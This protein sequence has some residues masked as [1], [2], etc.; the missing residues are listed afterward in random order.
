MEPGKGVKAKAGRHRGKTGHV[1][2]DL[3]HQR[4]LHVYFPGYGMSFQPASNLDPDHDGDVDTPGGGADTDS[5]APVTAEWSAEDW[6]SAMA[7][8]L[9]HGRS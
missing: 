5:P 8:V 4:V 3:G 2:H 9:E 6:E 7:Q 1:V